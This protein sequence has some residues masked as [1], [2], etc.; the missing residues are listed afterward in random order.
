MN[1]P[2]HDEATEPHRFVCIHV[3]D[4]LEK[5]PPNKIRRR[6]HVF[7]RARVL[8]P[9]RSFRATNTL[10]IQYPVEMKSTDSQTRAAFSAS[11]EIY[12]FI[13]PR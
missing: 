9:S 5:F 3:K 6:I 2:S 10:I 13:E 12:H 11:S 1:Q 7:P 4:L 8:A